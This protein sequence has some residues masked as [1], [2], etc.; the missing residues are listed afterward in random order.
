MRVS[1]INGRLIDPANNIDANQDVH[2]AEGRVAALGP[3]P[4]GFTA[5]RVIDVQDMVVCPGLIDLS[6]RVREPGLEHKATIESESRAA[7]VNGITTICTPPDTTPVVDTPAVVELIHQRATQAGSAR[8]EVV[9][10]LTAGLEGEKLAQMGALAE[11][12]CIA[13]GNADAPVRSTEIMRRAMEYAVTFGL[14]V[15]C[16]PEDPWLAAGRH[17]HE[18]KVSTRLGIRGIPATAEVIGLTRDL[19]LAEQTGAR[20]HFLHL[21]SARSV[22]LVE[23]A[24]QRGLPVTADVTAHHLHLTDTAL[25]GFNSECH[26]RPPLRGED[27]REAL[28]QSLASSGI[29]AVCSAHQPHE[30]DARL[31]PF[32]I[33]DPGSSALDTLLPLTLRLVETGVLSLG[34][35]VAALSWRP[36]QVLGIDRGRL[37]VGAPGDV[38]VFDPEYRWQ[39]T[40]ASMFSEGVNTPFAD[41]HFSGRCRFTLVG[42]E[43]VFSDA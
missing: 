36:A 19:L 25:L 31:N 16:R 27:D 37:E 24:K 7:V 9:G 17:V 5:D 41:Q 3:A 38:C 6:A 30:T 20:A 12:G 43:V 2:L 35:A 1:I 14:T 15:F 42:G 18:G 32:T 21:S 23:Q 8:V 10:A 4:D 22:E 34:D 26:L 13:V 28:R 39:L 40:P 29:D 11:A 33:T